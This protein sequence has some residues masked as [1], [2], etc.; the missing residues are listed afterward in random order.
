MPGEAIGIGTGLLE[1]AINQ[2][3]NQQQ[4]QQ[5]QNLMSIQHGNQ[6]ELNQQGHDLQFKMW[7]KTNYPEQVRMMKAAGL[8]PAL[9]YKGAGPGGTTGSQGGGAASKG[10]APQAWKANPQTLL[11]GLEMKALEAQIE[12]QEET[13]EGTRID[14]AIKRGDDA[15]G[16]GQ[17]EIGQ[18]QSN[19][20]S[21]LE[22]IKQKEIRYEID[23][24]TAE[25]QKMEIRKKAVGEGVKNA[26]NEAK[27]EL[28]KDQERQL[29]HK[30]YQDWA[31]VGFGALDDV[32]GFLT[33]KKKLELMIKQLT[34]KGKPS[35]VGNH[36][37]KT[38]GDHVKSRMNINPDYKGK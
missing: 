15:A 22:D 23:R 37:N 4:Y 30:I 9:M 5:E 33:N 32:L 13:N 28:T 36:T 2:A 3:T 18:L 31:K 12:G 10:S 19:V 6:Q 25:Y 17:L 24:E 16:R 11:M 35:N 29:E 21:T 14:N 26:L 7:Q 8:N 34:N 20:D 38:F 1:G 27:I